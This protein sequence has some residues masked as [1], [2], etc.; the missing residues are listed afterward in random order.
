MF[1]GCKSLKTLQVP[2]TVKTIE[3]GAFMESGLTFIEIPSVTA[4]DEWAFNNCKSLK[5]VVLN[6]ALKENFFM[7]AYQAFDGCTLLEI[8]PG[9]KELYYPAGFKFVEFK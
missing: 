5:S 8:K 4:I 2:T 6:K 7:G 9:T 1:E 3:G